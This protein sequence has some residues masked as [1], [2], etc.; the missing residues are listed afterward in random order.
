MKY[1]VKGNFKGNQN[2]QKTRF[3]FISYINHFSESITDENYEPSH[4]LPNTAVSDVD[5]SQ[6]AS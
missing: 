2:G 6:S 3:Y 1:Q 5:F 4:K